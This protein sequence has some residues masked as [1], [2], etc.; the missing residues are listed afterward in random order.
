MH[1]CKAASITEELSQEPA[2]EEEQ[3][4]KSFLGT[5]PSFLMHK[6]EVK[7]RNL[8]IRT[9][10]RAR[11]S[12]AKRLWHSRLDWGNSSQELH[13]EAGAIP[14]WCSDLHPSHELSFAGGLRGAEDVGQQPGENREQA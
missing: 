6:K 10:A 1:K 5:L 11:Q 4:V 14:S 2:E 9:V 3:E 12:K 8:G 13:G 7:K